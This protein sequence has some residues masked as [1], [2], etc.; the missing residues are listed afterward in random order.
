VNELTLVIKQIDQRTLRE[1]KAQ[2]ARR[3]LTLAQVF[4]EAVNLWLNRNESPLTTETDRDNEFYES[5]RAELEAEY[6]GRYI[7]ITSGRFIGVY[8]SL[9]QA[10]EAIK[11][12]SPRPTHAII[13]K[14][15]EDVKEPGEWLGGSL[16]Q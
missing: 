12:L 14:A 8:D 15:G 3:G 5:S 1:L 13:T 6:R 10:G 9:E 7:L 11:A 16:E 4:E 2:A